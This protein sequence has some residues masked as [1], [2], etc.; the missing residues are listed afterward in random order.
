[1]FGVGIKVRLANQGGGGGHAQCHTSQQNIK[2]C[3]QT[4][5]EDSWM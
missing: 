4:K 5:V 1:M 3:V 2:F